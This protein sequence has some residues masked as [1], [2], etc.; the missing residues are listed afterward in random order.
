[1]ANGGTLEGAESLPGGEAYRSPFDPAPIVRPLD[2]MPAL[3]PAPNPQP[4]AGGVGEPGDKGAAVAP[5]AAAEAAQEPATKEAAD[6]AE[7][8]A[9]Q[10]LEKEIME[11]LKGLAPEDMPNIEVK[12]DP[13]GVLISLTDDFRFGMFDVGSAVPKPEVVVVMEKVAKALSERE[14]KIV[15][16]GHTDGRPFK[17]GKNDN[18][19]LSMDRAQMAYYM[20]VRGGF[21]EARVERVEGHADRKL[22]IADDPNAAQNRRIEILLRT[23]TP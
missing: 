3:T 12:R 9:A 21:A 20:L 13:E 5:S 14:G 6:E 17:S 4:T 2:G 16:R 19:R 11:S 22:K 15:V 1:M 8:A 7:V 10:A 23:A 18:W